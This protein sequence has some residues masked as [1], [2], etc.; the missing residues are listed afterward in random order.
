MKVTVTKK[1]A[2]KKLLGA[3]RKKGE[4]IE[5]GSRN[6]RLFCAIGF[7]TTEIKAPPKPAKKSKK[8]A[9]KKTYKTRH[10]TAEK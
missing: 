4:V 9:S 6:A 7:A 3:Y 8:K 1:G 2:G 5:P 10:L